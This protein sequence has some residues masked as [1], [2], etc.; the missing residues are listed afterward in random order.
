MNKFDALV[1]RL[2][3]AGCPVKLLS[4]L[5]SE[6]DVSAENVSELKNI[7]NLLEMHE[8]EIRRLRQSISI[9]IRQHT[10][11]SYSDALGKKRGKQE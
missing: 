10:L 6:M 1:D 9:G 11:A 2:L 3:G 8:G 4:G 5:L 7:V